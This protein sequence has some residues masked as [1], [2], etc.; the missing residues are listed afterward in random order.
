MRFPKARS[1]NFDF[2]SVE[3]DFI[4]C[5]IA[6]RTM[7]FGDKHFTFFDERFTHSHAVPVEGYRMT[8]HDD[9]VR[10]T[11]DVKPSPLSVEEIE[12]EFPLF[13]DGEPIPRPS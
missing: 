13:A 8:I 2:K 5:V 12:I 7:I 1:L 3:G 4:F 9:Q 10:F 6:V 11:K